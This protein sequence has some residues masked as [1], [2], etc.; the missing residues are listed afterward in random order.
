MSNHTGRVCSLRSPGLLCSFTLIQTIANKYLHCNP[1]LQIIFTVLSDTMITR[2]QMYLFSKLPG[3]FQANITINTDGCW[4]W[5]KNMNRNGYG[6]VYVPGGK[7]EVAHKF[8]YKLLHGEYN[9]SL[10]LDH[11]YCK[12]RNCCNPTHVEPV[13]NQQNVHRGTATLFKKNIATR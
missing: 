5:S 9:E 2:T 11:V 12:H 3:K 13:T 4:L 6:R 7:R 8:I 1:C 10:L